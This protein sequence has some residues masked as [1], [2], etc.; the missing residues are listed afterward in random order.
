MDEK[1]YFSAIYE[2]TY[3][4]ILRYVVIKTANADAVEDIVQNVYQNFYKRIRRRGF[5]DI[6]EPKAFLITLAQKEL[7]KHYA[8]KKIQ[9]EKFVL[10]MDVQEIEDDLPFEKLIENRELTHRIWQ[11]VKEGPLGCYQAFVLFYGYDYSIAYIAHALHIT[12]QNVKSR[13]HRTRAV[14]RALLKGA[15][16]DE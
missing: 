16:D 10:D 2:E 6:Y 5:R 7:L 1:Q 3:A 15:Q 12:E 4:D 14:V 8:K 9:E 11:A 13:L